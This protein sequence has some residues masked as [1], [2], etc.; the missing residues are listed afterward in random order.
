MTDITKGQG[1][2]NAKLASLPIGMAGR[3]AAGFGKR[4]VGRDKDEVN[5]EVKK[6][7]FLVFLLVGFLEDLDHGINTSLVLP[8]NCLVLLFTFCSVEGSL[9]FFGLGFSLPQ[10]GSDILGKPRDLDSSD[11]L[12]RAR[13]WEAV[14]FLNGFRLGSFQPSAAVAVMPIAKVSASAGMK[15]RAFT[16]HSS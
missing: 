8:K 12:A 3:A 9:G 13:D 10:V 16:V 4:M 7:F 11:T 5:Q 14:D 6:D 15:E 1:R 2:R